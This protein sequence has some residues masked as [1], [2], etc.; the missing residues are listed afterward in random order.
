M[1]SA[2]Q[3]ILERLLTT[4]MGQKA[5][6]VHFTVGS[7]PAVRVDG[8]LRLLYEEQILQEEFVQGIVQSLLKPE[9]LAMLAEKKEV[10][11]VYTFS[12][13]MRAKVRVFM[14]QGFPSV[15][16]QLMPSRPPQLALLGLPESVQKIT[17]VKK[18]L[19][20]ITGPYGSGRSTT[21]LAI[22]EAIN[23]SRAA[24]VIT[25][26]AP[27]EQVF[28]DK[29]S[30]ID[31][32]EIGKDTP[33]FAAGLAHVAH[34]DVDV[35]FADG[36]SENADVRTIMEIAQGTTLVLLT[37]HA[38]NTLLAIDTLMQAF[39]E[40]QRAYARALLSEILVAVVAQ[41]LI[42]QTGGGRLVVAE[43]L[44]GT[45]AARALLREGRVQQ[46]ATIL[47]TSR[48]E[49]MTTLDRALADLVRSDRI[50]RETAFA[51]AQ[52]EGVFQSLLKR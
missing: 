25:L 10:I 24:Y 2:Q 35:L 49:G 42:S 37:L 47:Q 5:S 30:V 44:L 23:N 13:H 21:A 20:I 38:N 12:N 52:D 16:F 22:L 36:I 40:S 50:S 45:S 33:S 48:E 18:G 41:R 51:N 31:Q 17:Q 43:V 7:Q 19:V 39:P 4:A 15:I 26:E 8:Q 28:A 46:L 9:D 34:E 1:Q 32:R 29:K 11:I 27:V 14:Q 6:D 3:I